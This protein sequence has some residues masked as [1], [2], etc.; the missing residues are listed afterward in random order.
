MQ[1][2]I[3]STILSAMPYGVILDFRNDVW[4]AEIFGRQYASLNRF[5]CEQY[6]RNSRRRPSLTQFNSWD[7]STQTRTLDLKGLNRFW[8]YDDETIPT[9]HN[10]TEYIDRLHRFGVY[11]KNNQFHEERNWSVKGRY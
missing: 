4:V 8:F 5:Y 11:L 1:N 10:I 3:E 2:G 7:G 9:F 6:G